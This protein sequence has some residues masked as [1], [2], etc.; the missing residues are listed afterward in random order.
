MLNFDSDNFD[1][2]NLDNDN[3]DTINCNHLLS[4]NIANMFEAF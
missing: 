4:S 3:F 2:V 1:V